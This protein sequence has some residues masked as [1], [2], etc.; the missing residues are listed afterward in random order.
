MRKMHRAAVSL[1]GIVLTV[2][3]AVGTML[4]A[5]AAE[6]AAVA[7]PPQFSEGTLVNVN[8]GK[9]LQ[10]SRDDFLGS[11]DLVVQASCDGTVLQSWELIPVGTVTVISD[12]P[13]FNVTHPG[14][15]IRNAASGMCLD[16]RAGASFDGSPVQQFPCD[17]TNSNQQWGDFLSAD[18]SNLVANAHASVSRDALMTME[19]PAGSFSDG[20]PVEL[21]ADQAQSPPPAQEFLYNVEN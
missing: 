5:G 12:W 18:G 15:Q 3:T 8:S 1:A 2:G 6:A 16:D 19:I 9:C 21:F 14:Y 4:P 13:L 7:F 17:T 20:T 10:P 11:H